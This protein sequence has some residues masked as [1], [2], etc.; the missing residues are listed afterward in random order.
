MS[1]GPGV[2]AADSRSSL[3]MLSR[4]ALS[5]L[6]CSWLGCSGGRLRRAIAPAGA[7]PGPVVLHDAM[8]VAAAATKGSNTRARGPVIVPISVCAD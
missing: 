8:S 4:T 1:C 5:V 2:D 6:M 3:V 7:P